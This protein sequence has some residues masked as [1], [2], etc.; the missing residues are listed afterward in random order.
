MAA[1]LLDTNALVDWLGGV[2]SVTRLLEDISVRGNK[3]AACCVSIA[4]LYAGLADHERPRAD[5][6]AANFDYWD[7][8][9]AM[10]KQAGHYRYSYARRGIQLSAPDTLLAA[11]AVSR[12]ATLIT[13]NLKDFPMPEIKLLPLPPR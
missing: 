12:D 8:D 2:E 9:S 10:A 1:Y 13:A 7:I 3:F 11:L 6:L 4:E 5:Q